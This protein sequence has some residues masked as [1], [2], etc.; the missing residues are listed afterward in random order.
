MVVVVFIRVKAAA[1][2]EETEEKKSAAYDQPVAASAGQLQ[3]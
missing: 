1:F 2:D 3:V